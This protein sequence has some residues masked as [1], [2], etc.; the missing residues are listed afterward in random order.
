M[1]IPPK[2]P[3]NS[4]ISKGLQCKWGYYDLGLTAY[5]ET[6]HSLFTPFLTS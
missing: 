1:Q 6:S 2:I 4:N 3:L 5:K